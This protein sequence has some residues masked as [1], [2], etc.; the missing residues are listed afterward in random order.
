M[1]ERARGCVDP[2]VPERQRLSVV[3]DTFRSRHVKG[4][5]GF[6]L[7]YP[8]WADPR[9]LDS[10]A[11]LLPGRGGTAAGTV[12]DVG[13]GAYFSRLHFGAM[14]RRPF[15]LAAVDAGESYFH[16]RASGEDRLSLVMN[17]L[18]ELVARLTGARPRHEALLGVSMGG[19]GALLAAER[20]PSRYAA[21]AVAGPALFGSYADEHGSVGDAFDDAHDFA[22]YDV[23]AHASSL[24]ARVMVRCGD[25]DPFAPAVRRFAQRCPLADVRIVPGCHTDGF[26]RASAPSLLF[27]VARALN[28]RY[29]IS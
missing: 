9:V 16:P 15:V 10:A 8:D 13:F 28:G 20:A 4:N 22:A 6:V 17:E 7:A 29:P 26:W 27:F 24:R 1:R 11:Y 5:V 19:Y 2:G 23:I 25:R 14:G 3:A 12:D 21:V 18:P